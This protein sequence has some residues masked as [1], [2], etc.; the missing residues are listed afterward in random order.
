MDL[1]KLGVVIGNTIDSE[2]TG[3]RKDLETRPISRV[4]T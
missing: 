4:Y 1:Q 2:K 3:K